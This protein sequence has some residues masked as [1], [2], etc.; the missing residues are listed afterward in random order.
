[1][2]IVSRYLYSTNNKIDRL[3]LFKITGE[4]AT[5]KAIVDNIWDKYDDD[6]SNTLSKEEVKQFL[7]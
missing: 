1:M 7:E 5:F 6:S 2:D 4:Y 3:N